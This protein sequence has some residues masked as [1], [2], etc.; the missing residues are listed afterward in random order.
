MQF[1][2]RLMLFNLRHQQEWRNYN[3]HSAQVVAKLSRYELLVFHALQHSLYKN[4]D[5]AFRTKDLLHSRTRKKLAIV[6]YSR[7][8]GGKYLSRY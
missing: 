5:I 4:G 3:V 7:R 1:D 8:S 2:L 6:I